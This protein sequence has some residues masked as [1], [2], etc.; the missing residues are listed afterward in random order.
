MMMVLATSRKDHKPVANG[1]TI[2]KTSDGAVV[3]TIS[4]EKFGIVLDFKTSKPKSVMYARGSGPGRQ[5]A[6]AKDA[7]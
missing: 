4:L 7:N 1:L 6:A 5:I 3:R 2:E